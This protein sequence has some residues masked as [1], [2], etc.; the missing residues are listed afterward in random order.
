MNN[1]LQ[2]VYQYVTLQA[3]RQWMLTNLAALWRF[4]AKVTSDMFSNWNGDVDPARAI[5]YLIVLM[6]SVIF[7]WLTIL[8]TYWHH[9]FNSM[10]FSAGVGV[11]AVQVIAAAAGV[12][13]KQSSE[14]P[15]TPK[16]ED[17]TPPSQ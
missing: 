2:T 8:D 7:A 12:R 16:A 1:F 3:V 11:I 14:I 6:F 15:M 4:F 13:I 10:A 5:G 9:S 17:E